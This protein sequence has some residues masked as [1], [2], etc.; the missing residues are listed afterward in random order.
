MKS[1]V[2]AKDRSRVQ[3]ARVDKRHASLHISPSGG[4][5]FALLSTVIRETM[6]K[7]EVWLMHFILCHVHFACAMMHA[8]AGTQL[9][10]LLMQAAVLVA[11][12]LV[13]GA[14]S[15]AALPCLKCTI[16]ECGRR[17]CCRLC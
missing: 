16:A 6:G 11:P 7:P 3:V 12:Y 1:R 13:V 14:S 4:P 9:G 15:L 5:H 17:M 2:P 10:R 8:I